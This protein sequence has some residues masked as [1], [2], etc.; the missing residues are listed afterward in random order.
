M[1]VAG[2]LLRNY[3]SAGGIASS[4]LGT[5]PALLQ[6]LLRLPAGFDTWQQLGMALGL[7]GLVTG[8]RIGL[9]LTW[10]EFR[11]ATNV[12]NC[13]ILSPLGPLDILVVAAV[14]GLSEEWL[15]RG[16]II[17]ASFPDYRGVLL[18]AALFG[19][20]HNSGGRNLAFAAWAGVVGAMYGG[21]F[22]LTHNIWVPVLAHTLA[23]VASA[24][25]W[26]VGG[27]IPDDRPQAQPSPD[28]P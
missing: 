12:S 24:A 5:D 14:A 26:K 13:Q 21:V 4:V 27:L 22:L 11:H 1:V 28:Q 2:L 20:L 8:A 3:A 16:A 25:A 10:P 19:L 7:T 9:L 18:S 17:P 6:E 23:N 15:F